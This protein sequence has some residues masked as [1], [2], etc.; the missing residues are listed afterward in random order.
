MRSS[1]AVLRRVGPAKRSLVAAWVAISLGF[2]PFPAGA[3]AAEAIGPA[4]PM[5]SP[6]PTMPMPFRADLVRSLAP[7]VEQMVVRTKPAEWEMC[8]ACLYY[9]FAGRTLLA[10]HGI[11][12]SLRIGA[13]IYAPGTE[14]AHGISPHAWLETPSHFIDYSTLPRWGEVSIIPR[15]RVAHTP[16]AVQPGVSRVLTRLRPADPD[17]LGYLS[18]HGGRFELMLSQ[19]R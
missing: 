8:R 10:R 12:A 1:S 17:L 11:M 3:K 2:G 5:R 18:S 7:A 6:L 4:L 13:V 14:A 19:G 16:E 9:A 15:A